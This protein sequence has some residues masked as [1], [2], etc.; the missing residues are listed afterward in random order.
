MARRMV[1][2]IEEAGVPMRTLRTTRPGYIVHRDPQQIVAI[3][4]NPC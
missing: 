2:A 3:P 4:F 1:V